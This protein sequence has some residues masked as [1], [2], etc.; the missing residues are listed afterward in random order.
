MKKIISIIII[1]TILLSS[2]VFAKGDLIIKAGNP[3]IL[4]QTGFEQEV[5]I[6]FTIKNVGET[7]VTSRFGIGLKKDNEELAIS[8]PLYTFTGE[9]KTE[10]EI[11]KYSQGVPITDAKG[12][13]Y[14]QKAT[15]K[16]IFQKGKHVATAPTITLK[17]NESLAFIEKNKGFFNIFSVAKEGEHTF[18]YVVDVENEVD[19]SDETNNQVLVKMNVKAPNVIKGPNKQFKLSDKQYWFFF[20]EVGDCVDM[21]TPKKTKICLVDEGIFTAK[22]TINNE[23]V[24]LFHIFNIFSFDKKVANL[25]LTVSEDGFFLMYS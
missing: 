14:F 6:P 5:F 8:Y 4:P 13:E 20:K 25:E 11:F 21:E 9:V 7:D 19:E 16:D 18:T 2:V 24:T 17:P 10:G 23:Q 15:N 3:E 1:L 12:K 22:L